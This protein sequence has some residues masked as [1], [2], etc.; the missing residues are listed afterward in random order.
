[1]GIL[2][3][4]ERTYEEMTQIR[5][6]IAKQMD[7]ASRLCNVQSPVENYMKILGKRTPQPKAGALFVRRMNEK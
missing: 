7:L 1:M 3:M 4:R 2:R 5:A 6:A